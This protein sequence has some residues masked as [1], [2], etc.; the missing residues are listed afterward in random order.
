M[1]AKLRR[2]IH[3]QSQNFNRERKCQKLTNRNR[4][5]EYNNRTDNLIEGFNNRLDKAEYKINKQNREEWDSSSQR[6]KR[7]KK[8]NENKAA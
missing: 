7:E 4:G 2:T 5:E 3:E 8:K 6:S 1:L